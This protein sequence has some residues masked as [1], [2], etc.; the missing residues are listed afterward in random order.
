M[1]SL[2]SP[3][4]HTPK[5]FLRTRLAR[6]GSSHFGEEGPGLSK[7]TLALGEAIKIPGTDFVESLNVSVATAVILSDF[8]QKEKM[9]AVSNTRFK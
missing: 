7:D 2:L 8:Y 1:D 4:L 9:H 6:Q 3:L 5:K